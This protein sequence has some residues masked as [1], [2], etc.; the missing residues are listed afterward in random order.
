MARPCPEGPTFGLNPPIS[1]CRKLCYMQ[2]RIST[3][4]LAW[5]AAGAYLTTACSENAS[6]PPASGTVAQYLAFGRAQMQDGRLDAAVTAFRMALLRDRRNPDTLAELAAAYEARGQSG[7]ADRYLRRGVHLTYTRGLEALSAGDTIAAA[8]SFEHTVELM[9]QHPLAL[10]RLGNLAREKGELEEAIGLYTRA[11]SA[12]PDY[13]ESFVRLGDACAQAG[14]GEQ[15]RAAYEHAIEMNINAYD[16][17]VGLGGV[18]ADG[19]DWAGAAGNLQKALLVRP[20]SPAVRGALEG[21]RK[22]L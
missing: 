11:T 16:A 13:A 7:V 21:I 17:Y 20:D 4:V 8:R 5:L 15:A 2:R 1:I 9:P 22:R 6:V 14:R 19:G 18:L 12:N 10:V 3:V